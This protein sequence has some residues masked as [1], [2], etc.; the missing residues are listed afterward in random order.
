[1]KDFDKNKVSFWY[2]VRTF[3]KIGCI[4]FGG[5]MALISI[6][7]KQV[8]EKDKVIDNSDVLDG[9]SLASILPGPVAVNVVTYIG[10]KLRGLA[11][12]L[13][14]MVSVILPSFILMIILSYFYFKYGNLP[15]AGKTF[16]G[17][18]PCI[19]ATILAVSINMGKNSLKD[20]RQYI[21]CFISA[22]L[23]ILFS[24]YFTTLIIIIFSGVSGYLI[25]RK[26]ITVID[27]SVINNNKITVKEAFKFVTPVIFVLLIII[28]FIFSNSFSYAGNSELF[29]IFS[30][31]GTMGI[32]LLG[33]GYVFIPMIHDII[34][35]KL[36][37]LNSREFADSI[38]LGQIT[39]GPIMI[40]S[41]FIGYKLMK[42][43]GALVAT[44]G[45]FFVPGILMI[46]CSKYYLII[47]KSQ[48][49]KVALKG[50]R[51]AV[52]GMIFSAVYII[53]GSSRL[54]LLSI[55]IFLLVF[56]LSYFKKIDTVILI[57]FSGLVGFLFG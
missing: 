19:A 34:V 56:L 57:L 44:V 48:L 6:V 52:I 12:A 36:G 42:L 18:I 53:A 3:I 21:I 17:I 24:G 39:P 16:S 38:A 28:F 31:F 4:S 35:L 54:N 20:Y 13:V 33:G 1:L 15:D 43:P 46:I 37:W 9:I 32:T 51:A 8:A 10:Y 7:Q 26:E 47:N 40:S 25:Y 27:T 45:M 2:L 22:I 30:T 23:L 14:S 41:T 5:F 50:I 29:R 11:G 55:S 49:I